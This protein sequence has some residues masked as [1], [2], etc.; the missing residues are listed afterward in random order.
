MRLLFVLPYGPSQTRVRSRML[1]ET[2]AQR[3]QITLVA[4]VWDAADLRALLAWRERGVVVHPIG[5]GRG[6]R[7]RSLCGDPRRPLQQ[8]ASTSPRLARTVRALLADA[9]RSGQPYDALHVEHLRGAAALRL[10]ADLPVRVVF[11]AVDCIAELARLTRRHNP[12]PA[13]RWVAAVEEGRTRRLETALVGAADAVAVVAARD[14]DALLSGGAA[15]R[16]TVIPNGVPRFVR[17]GNLTA[18]PIV[19][20]TGKLSYHANAAAL[21]LFLREIWP[22][23]RGAVPA[24]RLLVAG[25]DPPDWLRQV[26]GRDGVMLNAQPPEMLPLIAAARVA[27]APMTYS[28]GVQNKVLEAMACAV[29]VVATAAAAEGLLPAAEGRVLVE[30]ASAAFAQRVVQ[31]LG[32]DVLAESLGL[33]GQEYVRAHHSWGQSAAQFEALYRAESLDQ[34]MTADWDSTKVA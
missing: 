28:V 3:H 8:I 18:E 1:L 19:I 33:A 13:L 23:V 31:L 22:L 30:D 17:H 5:H 7:L 12:R 24:A 26:V 11:D 6:A 9:A 29:P 20:F 27:V 14:R 4:L 25:A 10:A 21:R 32:D 15:E 16:I 34:L 2:L